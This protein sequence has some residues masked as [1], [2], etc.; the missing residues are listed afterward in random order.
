MSF[1]TR[2]LFQD[3]VTTAAADIGIELDM[4]TSYYKATGLSQETVVQSADKAFDISFLRDDS[5]GEP[6]PFKAISGAKPYMLRGLLRAETG[7][8]TVAKPGVRPVSVIVNLVN[9]VDTINDAQRQL[10]REPGKD[11]FMLELQPVGEETVAGQF[12]AGAR[13]YRIPAAGY[14]DWY[15]TFHDRDPSDHVHAWIS[16]P[17]TTCKTIATAGQ[18]LYDAYNVR[19][20][21]PEETRPPAVVGYAAALDTLASYTKP[22]FSVIAGIDSDGTD[23]VVLRDRLDHIIKLESYTTGRVTHDEAA[24]DKRYHFLS[25]HCLTKLGLVGSP[26]NAKKHRE[27]YIALSASFA[28]HIAGTFIKLDEI[29]P[30]KTDTTESREIKLGHWQS[31]VTEYGTAA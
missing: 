14:R 20:Y 10:G 21:E 11:A 8:L 24:I 1:E 6:V 26:S 29:R 22:L 17:S 3:V 16:T 13:K 27:S 18:A 23:P 25:K 28:A 7:T 9:S 15:W 5:P 2:Q 31:I 12:I 19:I 4:S 30:L